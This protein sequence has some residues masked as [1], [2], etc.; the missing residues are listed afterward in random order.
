[1]RGIEKGASSK[2]LEA[3]GDGKT[4]E[5]GRRDCCPKKTRW[6]RLGGIDT[7]PADPKQTPS[8]PT[9][10]PRWSS[11]EGHAAFQVSRTRSGHYS[12]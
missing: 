5:G 1:M 10:Q 9:L 3:C 6:L 4:K 11:L 7:L 8:P 12:D 2:A